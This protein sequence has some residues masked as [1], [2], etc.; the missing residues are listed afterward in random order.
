G[1]CGELLLLSG[2]LAALLGVAA[3][4]GQVDLKRL[5]AYSSIENI[6]IVFMGLGLWTLGRA[7]GRAELALLGL[8][9][10]LLHV[11]NHS[12]F[13]PLLFFAAGAVIHATGTRELDQLGGLLPRMPRTGRCFLV[14]AGAIAGLPLLN[15][16][17]GEFALYRGLFLLAVQPTMWVALLAMLALAGLALVSGLALLAFVRCTAAVFL[18]RPRT[19]ATAAAHE[20]PATMT[21]PLLLLAALCAGIGRLPQLGPP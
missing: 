6:G 8:G 1:V 12:L 17:I 15:G 4:L 9:A 21:A 10:A 5:L 14:G 2:T 19:A 3:T 7:L 20:A 18:G 11:L 16:F 13:K